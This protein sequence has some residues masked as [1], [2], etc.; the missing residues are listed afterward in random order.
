M[1]LLGYSRDLW[2][3]YFGRDVTMLDFYFGRIDVNDEF[4]YHGD[5]MCNMSSI[6]TMLRRNFG[7]GEPPVMPVIDSITIH[8][9]DDPGRKKKMQLSSFYREQVP[10]GRIIIKQ[11]N[12]RFFGSSYINYQLKLENEKFANIV[13]ISD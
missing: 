6:N 7:I 11:T 4:D 5:G 8:P 10:R 3:R 2:D 12:R 9:S 13:S 1:K